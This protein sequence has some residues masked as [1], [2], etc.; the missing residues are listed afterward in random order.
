[1]VIVPKEEQKGI[2]VDFESG[3]ETGCQAIVNFNHFDMG[4]GLSIAVHKSPFYGYGRLENT[5][6]QF[7]LSILSKA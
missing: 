1:M 7:F 5:S 4:S 3:S 6:E 2:K